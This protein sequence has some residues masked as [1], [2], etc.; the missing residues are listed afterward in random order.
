M[1]KEIIQPKA[2]DGFALNVEIDHEG[3]LVTQEDEFNYDDTI[4]LD[5]KQ[6]LELARLIF[7]V[8]G[9]GQ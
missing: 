6:A 9:E 2:K 3:L 5:K 7:G 4:S 8:L 1:R